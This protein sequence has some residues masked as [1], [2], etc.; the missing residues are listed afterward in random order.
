MKITAIHT[1]PASIRVRPDKA[2]TGSR[3]A[4]RT[5]AFVLLR[6]ETDSGI[7]GV[8]EATVMPAWSGETVWSAKT[9]IDQI[10]GP[11]LIGNDPSDIEHIADLMDREVSRNW[12]TKAALE[13]ACWDIFGKAEG[14][15]V[16][17]LLGGPQRDR[18]VRCRFSMSAY[19]PERAAA[20]ARELVADGFT[21]IKVKVG[22][23]E[24]E[25]LARVR[26]VREAVGTDVAVTI[27]AGGTRRR[28]S[29]VA[30]SW[31]TCA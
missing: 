18:T 12:F 24:A 28:R 7:A 31:P 9:L 20:R 8:G 26:R 4:H 15:P 3:G 2:I 22:I 6:M 30:G 29:A 19:P 10:L 27:A 16:Y 23:D 11:L 1:V 21:T 13:M 5:S 25:D 14:K 17:E